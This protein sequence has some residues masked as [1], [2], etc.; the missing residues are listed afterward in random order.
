MAFLDE[1]NSLL[2]FVVLVVNNPDP[3]DSGVFAYTTL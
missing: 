2:E 3:P 1:A